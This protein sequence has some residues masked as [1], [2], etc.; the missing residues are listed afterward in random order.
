MARI[1]TSKKQ[2]PTPTQRAR[3]AEQRDDAVFNRVWHER[4]A[5]QAEKRRQKAAEAKRKA[6]PQGGRARALALLERLLGTTPVT[7][8]AAAQ[9]QRDRRGRQ[10]PHRNPAKDRSLAGKDRIR[11]RRAGAR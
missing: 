10:L 6:G 1:T 11:A 5:A 4:S 2:Q 7:E 9:V 3:L 8:T